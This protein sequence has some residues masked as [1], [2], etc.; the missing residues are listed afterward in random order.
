MSTQSEYWLENWMRE[1]GIASESDY[2]KAIESPTAVKALF[3]TI[4]VRHEEYQP[5]FAPYTVMAGRS[6]D[7]SASFHVSCFGCLKSELETVVMRSSHYFNKIAVS[8]P[9]TDRLGFVLQSGN[10]SERKAALRD[11]WAHVEII[12]FINEVGIRS[13]FQFI[14]KPSVYCRGCYSKAAREAG[15]TFYDDHSQ[16]GEIV[17]RILRTSNFKVTRNKDGNWSAEVSG[18]M[19]AGG[20]TWATEYGRSRPKRARI[21]EDAFYYLAN[22]T[23][24]DLIS[25]QRHKLPVI[26]LAEVDW[27]EILRG[28]AEL[29]KV[30]AIALNVELPTLLNVSLRDFVR[31]EQDESESF[32]KFQ[33]ATRKAVHE[34]LKRHDSASP[35]VIAKAV[36]D[37]YIKP[38]LADIE[39]KIKAAK[40]SLGKKAAASVAVGATVTSIG[41]ATAMPLITTA[42]IA[43]AATWLPQLYKFFDDKAGVESS[44]LYFLWKLS[45]TAHEPGVES[46]M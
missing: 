24:Q 22:P 7:L 20:G 11:L 33:A 43:A 31:L 1:F 46:G 36:V 21:A 13:K 19:I 29:S 39:Q 23:V 15:M 2:V 38:E 28:R 14:T 45:Q 42:G 5:E 41:L 4:P 40:G 27:T 30:E 26:D 9:M 8:G 10:K 35:T 16:R 12:N 34:A 32:T 18:A 44:E 6:L 37:E 25:S 17:E 3:E